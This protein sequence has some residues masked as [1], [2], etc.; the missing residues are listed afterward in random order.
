MTPISRRGI[1]TAYLEFRKTIAQ[2]IAK[3][4]NDPIP[5]NIIIIRT[6]KPVGI[7]LSP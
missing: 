4:N 2:M 7:C 3:V 6:I 5:I 1:G